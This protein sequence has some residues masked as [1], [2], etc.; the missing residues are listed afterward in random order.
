MIEFIP[1]S[2]RFVARMYGDYQGR[3]S[4]WDGMLRFLKLSSISK[5]FENTHNPK[6][7]PFIA[8]G[9]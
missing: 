7:N 1:A 6:N 8:G 9:A 5:S 4:F 3:G 2:A